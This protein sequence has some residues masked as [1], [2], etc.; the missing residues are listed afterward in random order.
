MM[1]GTNDGFADWVDGGCQNPTGDVKNAIEALAKLDRIEYDQKREAFAKE[2]KIRVSTLDAEVQKMR[3]CEEG[4]D[5]A[6][7]DFE[8]VEPWGETVNGADCWTRLSTR[9]NGSASYLT[10]RPRWWQLGLFTHGRMT[11]LTLAPCWPSHRLKSDA[12]NQR[13]WP[14]FMRWH[15]RQRL[16]PISRRLS[17]FV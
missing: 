1:D 9:L 11:H 6:Q 17:C 14:W 3:P 15:P 10:T 8:T 7:V 5:T 4:D 16:P 2:H 13:R 12:V